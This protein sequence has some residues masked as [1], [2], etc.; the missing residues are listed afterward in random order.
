MLLRKYVPFLY[1]SGFLAALTVPGPDVCQ[2]SLHF[3][4]YGVVKI[5]KLQKAG[6]SA[7]EDR[8]LVAEGVAVT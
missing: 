3:Y 2:R 4:A 8:Q 6:V 5:L 1:L 7:E